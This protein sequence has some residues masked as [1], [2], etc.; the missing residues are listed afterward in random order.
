MYNDSSSKIKCLINKIVITMPRKKKTETELN[1]DDINSST[2]KLDDDNDI[3]ISNNNN[4]DDNDDDEV[5][6]YTEIK[7][8]LV[9]EEIVKV[10]EL[11]STKPNESLQELVKSMNND[12]L[13]TQNQEAEVAEEKL[14]LFPLYKELVKLVKDRGIDN[15]N[16]FR[17]VITSEYPDYNQ[18]DVDLVWVSIAEYANRVHQLYEKI[19]QYYRIFVQNIVEDKTLNKKEKQQKIKTIVSGNPLASYVM[20]VAAGEVEA[21]YKELYYELEGDLNKVM[22]LLG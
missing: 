14:S 8:S 1:T 10:E 9:D 21:L 11:N 6:E 3:N 18:A 22:K 17:D 5:L 13:L 15:V 19:Y 7:E 12:E 20:R 2:E 4:D 16:T